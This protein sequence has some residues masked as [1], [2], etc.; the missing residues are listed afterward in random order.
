MRVRLPSQP[1]DPEP[2]GRWVPTET[3][4]QWTAAGTGD[5]REPRLVAPNARVVSLLL[6]LV[7]VGRIPATAEEPPGAQPA[8]EETGGIQL[9]ALLDLR[10]E[11]GTI[12]PF[13]YG[14]SLETLGRGLAAG[15]SAE[16]LKDRK[17]LNPPTASGSPW[18]R[19]G[20]EIGWSLT[21]DV[22]QA[23][24][25]RGSV[26]ISV[27]DRAQ[28]EVH[29]IQQPNLPL[30]A[31][32]E[33]VGYVILAGHG[34][35]QAI[36][37][38]GQ[39]VGDRD[40]IRIRLSQQN[41]GRYPIRF[42]PRTTTDAGAL[43]I[44]LES[45]GAVWIG[46]ASLMPANHANGIRADTLALLQDLNTPIYRWPGGRS[47]SGYDWRDGIGPAD[48]RPP[49]PHPTA[50][51]VE[52]NDFGIDEF[53]AFCRTV[54]AEPLV[55]VDTG[56]GSPELA[57]ALV[58]YCNGSVRT[59]WGRR[60]ALNGQ[61]EPY[62]VNWWG[63]G[64][65]LP[66]DGQSEPMPVQ[67]QLQRHR[68]F[69]R[70]MRTADNTIRV[71][72]T[73]QDGIWRRELLTQDADTMALLS[74]AVPLPDNPN[75]EPAHDAIR[76]ALRTIAQQ[77][78]EHDENRPPSPVRPV[79]IAFDNWQAAASSNPLQVGLAVAG[80]LHELTR[81][82]EWFQMAHYAPNMAHALGTIQLPNRQAALTAAGLSLKLYRQHFGTH[83]LPVEVEP[84]PEANWLDVAAA[85]TPDRRQLSLGLVNLS[86]RNA[87]L[88]LT[89]LGGSLGSQATRHVIAA[90]AESQ[91]D[92]PGAPNVHLR[93]THT[94]NF[95]PAQMDLPPLSVSLFRV[96][97][98]AAAQ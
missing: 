12:N 13:L 2:T 23:Y 19:V 20:S 86:S 33:Y 89:I 69:V 52:S 47:L 62:N 16:L 90:T 42:R 36:L 79:P 3:G 45:T 38:W 92:K 72:A 54:G 95:D 29:G 49:R 6:I 10:Q 96:P 1:T 9:R 77:Y 58:E 65:G 46:G 83:S 80:G 44:G 40:I 94:N 11:Q 57:A 48:R 70:A 91:S 66:G 71:V 73:S 18:F 74:E 8:T 35:V 50:G 21:F 4:G 17:F 32:Q 59:A 53:L 64:G 30:I 27:T 98:N 84:D 78:R 75:R 25:G 93:E 14:Q 24:T 88:N 76:Q 15:F 7:L 81:H 26:K 41:F 55:V 61:T 51:N 68:E 97:V 60:R 37:E 87:T 63:I 85:L 67:Q 43:S 5:Q 31:G 34:L 82:P 28:N 56:L 22:E 39:G